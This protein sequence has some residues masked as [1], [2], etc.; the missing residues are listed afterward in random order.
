MRGIFLFLSGLT[1][2]AAAN[3]G[4]SHAQFATPIE[5][6]HPASH[7]EAL[8]DFVRILKPTHDNPL[9]FQPI[10]SDKLNAGSHVRIWYSSAIPVPIEVGPYNA[11]PFDFVT[12]ILPA[13][14]NGDVIVPI[15]SSPA[16]HPWKRGMAM[17]VYTLAKAP[18]Q[19]QRVRMEN[20]ATVLQKSGALI[21]H[22]FT[23]EQFTF[24]T[25]SELAGYR[26]GNMSVSAFLGF[27]MIL[28]TIVC[29]RG[30]S[31]PPLITASIVCCT[32]LLLYEA[33]FLLDVIPRTIVHQTEWQQEHR[34]G[35]MGNTYAI[36][37]ALNNALP[38][39]ENSYV[40]ACTHLATP[41]GY[42]LY[43]TGLA[44]Q[45]Y[46]KKE[47]THAIVL[48]TW[49]EDAQEIFCEGKRYSAT[50]LKTFSDGEA[51]AQIS[52]TP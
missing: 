42:F 51:I 10:T 34:Y 49:D 8:Q 41:Y 13:N 3:T 14:Q 39:E 1:F 32:F 23:P 17:K 6:H 46:L 21:K 37:E 18:T 19:I 15:F 9:S 12:A 29:V 25:M 22:F 5:S 36:A 35:H 7:E 28:C 52:P 50:I 33:R 20:E 24:S 31:R 38:E 30:S 48:N 26:V 43:P 27:L 2:F 16:W 45:D 40:L 44:A 47:P 4:I 11:K